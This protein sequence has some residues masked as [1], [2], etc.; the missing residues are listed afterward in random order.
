MLL[1]ALRP[2]WAEINLSNAG[3]NIE[4]IKKRAAKSE[5]I[6]IIKANAY[7]HGAV[8]YANMLI[9]HG[10]KRVGVAAISEAAALREGGIDCPII[11]LGLTPAMYHPAILEYNITPV[12]SNFENA[13]SFSDLSKD[14]EIE[15]WVAV[16]TG[17]GRVGVQP[18]EEG[19]NE[20]QKI[21][22][23]PNVKIGALFSHFAKA[24]ETDKSYTKQQIAHFTH[25][26]DELI[27]RGVHISQKTIA[28]SAGIIDHPEAHYDIVRPGIILYG[29][30]PSDEVD[31]SIIDLKPVM[32]IKAN[33]T[34]LKK[35]PSGT[36]I[37]YGGIFETKRESLIATLPLGYADGYPRA[38][39]G[40]THVIIHGQFAP[41]VGK[42]C[43]DQCMIDVTDIPNV[44]EGDEVILLGTDGKLTISAEELGQKTGTINYEILSR[45]GNRIPRVYVK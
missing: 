2:V 5:V 34:L 20:I 24:D 15:L 17:M 23:L 26:Y 40:K 41:I 9:E 29:C 43:M 39:T 8:E 18:N 10:I 11:M 30:Y 21:S 45:M 22:Q 42:I 19:I 27:K 36:L 6:G 12:V 3:H 7:G 4:Q 14:K 25:V 44:K 38:L 16:D 33:I 13:K 28:N 1:E 37:S 32:T 35:V 31:K